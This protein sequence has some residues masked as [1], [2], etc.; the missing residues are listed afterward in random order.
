MATVAILTLSPGHENKSRWPSS[1]KNKVQKNKIEF[2]S[3]KS[4]LLLEPEEKKKYLHTVAQVLTKAK[5]ISKVVNTPTVFAKAW[6]EVVCPI[7]GLHP[8][9]RANEEQC[10]RPAKGIFITNETAERFDSDFVRTDSATERQYISCPDGQFMCN[11]ALLGFNFENDKAILRCLSDASNENCLALTT[12]GDQIS[13]S[14][15]LINEANPEFWE[16]FDE[17][18]NELCVEDGEFNSSDEGCDYIRRQMKHATR[19]YN[20]RLTIRYKNI[21]RA[22]E[23]D[24][25]RSSNMSSNACQETELDPDLELRDFNRS[26]VKFVRTEDQCYRIPSDV[27]VR[28][29]PDGTHFYFT[30]NESG[31]QLEATHL[32][33][34]FAN[35]DGFMHL[36]CGPCNRYAN[37]EACVEELAKPESQRDTLAS[38]SGSNILS[39]YSDCLAQI[40]SLKELE[41]SDVILERVDGQSRRG[42]WETISI[43]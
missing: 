40:E 29:N 42:F 35:S 26:G 19:E 23:V 25:L 27:M 12:S 8:A 14:L 13:D 2:L 37:I 38:M 30:M 41:V 16:E 43:D 9:V 5:K 4:L 39:S 24:E 11:P 20:R 15:S 34:L 3:K 33:A 18:V 32:S 7:Y 21:A 22:I 17:G 10:A 1:I 6:A 36:N 28:E 31:E